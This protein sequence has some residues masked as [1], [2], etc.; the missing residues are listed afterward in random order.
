MAK[1]NRIKPGDVLKIDLG[2]GSFAFARALDEPYFA[3]YDVNLKTDGELDVDELLAAGTVIFK[4]AVMKGAAL[5]WEKH[6]H[7]SLPPELKSP[8]AFF[9]QDAMN[10]KFFL[11][12]DGVETPST[13]AE[14]EHLERAAVWEP[15]HVEDRLRDY[16]SGV[17][18]A[19]VESLRPVPPS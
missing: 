13:F 10:G 19:W 2:N 15:E 16:F 17:P 9:R 18:N 8:I 14:C 6:G 1:R 12:V 3:F 11:H 5:R 4:L 7:H